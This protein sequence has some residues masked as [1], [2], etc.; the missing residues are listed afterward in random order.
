M[1][2]SPWMGG[3]GVGRSRLV[4]HSPET[5][6]NTLLVWVGLRREIFGEM[7]KNAA[8]GVGR[9]AAHCT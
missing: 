3:S 5:F 6:F 8:H 4:S 7:L 2:R 1:P 9:H